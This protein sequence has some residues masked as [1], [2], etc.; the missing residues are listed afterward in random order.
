MTKE[1][2]TPPEAGVVEFGEEDV[3]VCSGGGF[4]PVIKPPTDIEIEIPM[5]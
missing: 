1:M 5:G 2:Y 4:D 3:V